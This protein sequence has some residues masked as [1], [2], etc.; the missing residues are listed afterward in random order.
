VKR[1]A[2]VVAVAVGISCAIGAAGYV[3]SRL[4]NTVHDAVRHS[5][6]PGHDE[7][8]EANRQIMIHNGPTAFGNVPK[9]VELARV[10]SDAQKAARATLFEGGKRGD[11]SL[12]KG[13]FLTYC[14]LSDPACVFLVHVPEMRQYSADARETLRTL[15]W[16][17]ARRALRDK[18]LTPDRLV[19]ALRGA[20][21]FDSISIGTPDGQPT[22]HAGTLV[23]STMLYP[24][25]RPPLPR[26]RRA[27]AA[28]TPTAPAAG[29][30]RR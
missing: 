4:L 12:A 7:F 1:L 14:R 2:A 22:V 27:A 23:D 26:A 17:M 11:L 19:V 16:A 18:G 29:R 9:A 13:E 21:L 15:S 30:A 25:F 28:E 20:V 10:F 6:T 3:L 5:P 24:Y 8:H